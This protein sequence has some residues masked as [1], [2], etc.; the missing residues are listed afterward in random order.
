MYHPTHPP[1]P[2]AYASTHGGFTRHLPPSPH[3]RVFHPGF[4]QS[5]Y[6][7]ADSSRSS[8]PPAHVDSAS[9]GYDHK[10][11]PFTPRKLKAGDVLFWHHLTRSGEIPG[12]Q[13]DQRARYGPN[14][15]ADNVYGIVFDR[16]TRFYFRFPPPP[17]RPSRAT[18][19]HHMVSLFPL[20]L[21]NFTSSFAPVSP[22]PS[23]SRLFSIPTTPLGIYINHINEPIYELPA[24]LSAR[25]H[26]CPSRFGPLIFTMLYAK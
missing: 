6:S 2:Y 14:P 12:I 8:T 26:L 22:M 3:H 20:S 15:L 21:W 17:P 11:L 1:G 18:S 13:D 4:S 9:L 19:R 7:S 16:Q 25:A 24:S 10:E 5:G 23:R